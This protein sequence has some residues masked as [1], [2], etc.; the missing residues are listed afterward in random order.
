MTKPL[1]FEI[2]LEVMWPQMADLVTLLVAAQIEPTH[3]VRIFD[4]DTQNG[5]ARKL[6]PPKPARESPA[7]RIALGILASG[8][9]W[10]VGE[11]GAQLGQHGYAQTTGQAVLSRLVQGGDAERPAV[12]TYRITEQGIANLK[13][14]EEPNG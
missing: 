1:K 8:D 3:V 4:R 5:E 9:T 6:P 7:G 2:R 13:N 12:A 10:S 11:F 14:M